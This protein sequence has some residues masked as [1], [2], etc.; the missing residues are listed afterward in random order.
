MRNISSAS[1]TDAMKSVFSEFGYPQHIHSNSGRQYSSQEVNS[2]VHKFNVKH[3]ISNA[4]CFVGIVKRMLK[5]CHNIYDVLHVY[6]SMPLCNSRH[7]PYELLFN[8]RMKENVISLT[9]YEPGPQK[10]LQRN[11]KLGQQ[12]PLQRKFELGPQKPLQKIPNLS[13]KSLFVNSYRL[14]QKP[15]LLIVV[16]LKSKRSPALM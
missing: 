12:K 1:C 8:H 14:N 9:H 11:S 13:R 16:L 15:I 5:K 3:T 10:P 7:S 2:F 4:Q 6:R